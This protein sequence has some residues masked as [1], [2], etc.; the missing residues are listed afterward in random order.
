MLF[1]FFFLP[2]LC[3]CVLKQFLLILTK[4]SKMFSTIP[5]SEW[6]FCSFNEA[7]IFVC[8]SHL[9]QTSW[10]WFSLFLLLFS[11]WMKCRVITM[12]L[13]F[14][15][16]Y[17]LIEH[18]QLFTNPPPLFLQSLV[19]LLVHSLHQ[20]WPCSSGKPTA[21]NWLQRSQRR[22]GIRITC[23]G[24]LIKVW[25]RNVASRSLSSWRCF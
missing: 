10:K 17:F 13:F 20:F 11:Q 23:F 6:Y 16:W 1:F 25:F 14:I 3:V 12:L 15:C 19:Q 18:K 5:Y 22:A 21:A 24:S 8:V 9:K 2:G 4:T 7:N